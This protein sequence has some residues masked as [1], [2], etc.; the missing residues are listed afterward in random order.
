MK[1][2]L[3]LPCYFFIF[4]T[5]AHA[6]TN[7]EKTA[8]IVDQKDYVEEDLFSGIK[9]KKQITPEKLPKSVK[10][11]LELREYKNEEITHTYL[12]YIPETDHPIYEI[13]IERDKSQELLYFD[14]FGLLIEKIRK[15]LQKAG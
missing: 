8:F 5:M 9:E 10:A 4:F 2:L 6:Q 15:P 3:L 12:V 7:R 13:H 11:G 1:K 14:H